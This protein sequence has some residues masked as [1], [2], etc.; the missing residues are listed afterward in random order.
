MTAY[1]QDPFINMENISKFQQELG[2][3]LEGHWIK[4]STRHD[5][6]GNWQPAMDILESANAYQYVLDLPGV[7]LDAVT[8]N[9]HR[10]VLTIGGER[11]P[12]YAS[13]YD[14]ENSHPQP[15]SNEFTATQIERQSGRFLKTATLPDDAQEE[16][17][18]A[19]MDNGVLTITVSKTSVVAPRNIPVNRTT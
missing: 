2:K 15:H 18:S 11:R 3:L 19:Q 9:I 17:C 13:K 16:D 6:D 1:R 5:R 4:P 10:G 14:G 7:Q 12:K 8:V